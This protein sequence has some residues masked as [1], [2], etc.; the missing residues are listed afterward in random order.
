MRWIRG[1]SEEFLLLVTVVAGAAVGAIVGLFVDPGSD[2]RAAT[3]GL[4]AFL[5]ALAFAA[6]WA[7]VYFLLHVAAVVLLINAALKRG[8][9]WPRRR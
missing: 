8:Y 6:L 9:R 3:V 2:S 5:G 1:R 7:V 4:W